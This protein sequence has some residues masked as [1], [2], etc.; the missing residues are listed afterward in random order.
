M[1]RVLHFLS[2]NSYSG[3]ENVVCYIIKTLSAEDYTFAYASPSGTI[4][5]YLKEKGIYHIDIKRNSII[6]IKKAIKL[7]KPTIIHAHDYLACFLVSL[8][9]FKGKIIFH[10][11]KTDT[12]VSKKTLKAFLFFLASKKASHIFWVSQESLNNYY[13][14]KNILQKS[15]VLLN[16]I[17]SE[18]VIELSNERV[19]SHIDAVFVGRLSGPKNPLR[20]VSIVENVV[21]NNPLFVIGVVGD[22]ELKGSLIKEIEIKHLENNFILY[23]Q[24]SNP[25]PYIKKANV[26]IMTSIY[27]GMPMVALEAF[28]LKTPIVSTP[29]GGLASLITAG[30]NGFLETSDESFAKKILFLI[31]GE[32]SLVFGENAH[33][34]FYQVNNESNYKKSLVLEYEKE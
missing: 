18:L 28:C 4:N 34:T 3:A 5:K 33:K 23:G 31:S 25:F 29:V 1:K 15:S 19:E 14:K 12:S 32:N 26:L 11:H 21:K 9:G 20:L 16:V 30:Y 13:Y 27:E 6:S 24:Q 17:D 10:I 22:G 8:S 7:Y 2:S